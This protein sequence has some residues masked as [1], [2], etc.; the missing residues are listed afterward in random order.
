MCERCPIF[1]TSIDVKTK[2]IYFVMLTDHFHLM[3]LIQC[4]PVSADLTVDLGASSRFAGN[5]QV[6]RQDQASV[7]SSLKC[8]GSARWL[9]KVSSYSHVIVSSK[10]TLLQ[11]WTIFFF[12]TSR[13]TDQFSNVFGWFLNCDSLY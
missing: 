10:I 13:V 7:F 3:H 5:G 9:L 6:P 2:N 12:F 1:P 8:E 4:W 11:L